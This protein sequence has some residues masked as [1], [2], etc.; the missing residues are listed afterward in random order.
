MP[1]LRRIVAVAC[2]PVK[3]P[4]IG[5]LVAATAIILLAVAVALLVGRDEGGG[6]M[7][8]T[9]PPPSSAP[10]SVPGTTTT[11][12][13]ATTTVPE[14]TTTV[15]ATTTTTEAAGNWADV[16]L[17]V[18][19]FGAL[20]W[21]DGTAWVQAEAGTEL[22]VTGG[23]DY[24]VASLEVTGTTTGGPPTILCDPLGNPGVELADDVLG[25]W[26]GPVGVAVSAG[27]DLVPH[28]V[29]PQVDDGTYA[30]FARDLLASRGLDVADPVITQLLR[31]DLEGDGTDEALAVAQRLADP[32]GLI[33]QP[34]DYSIVFLRK[35][36]GSEVQTAILADSI[37]TELDE[38]ASPY[39]EAHAIGAVADLS[40]DGSM[41][42]VVSSAY[43]EGI[44]VGIWEWA[45]PDLGPVYRIGSGCGA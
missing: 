28:T 41:E 44:G 19:D 5:W 37:V 21:W 24:A 23:E 45:G 12:N 34:G 27:W 36:V 10:S 8:T 20:G 16:P 2:R 39:V 3:D 7:T 18:A 22:P 17:V 38:G 29:E 26:P 9:S 1:S 35:I 40:G 6:A 32:S 43:Y 25:S 13:D 31:V 30:G 33:A 4:R 11:A 15:P 14:A 42:I